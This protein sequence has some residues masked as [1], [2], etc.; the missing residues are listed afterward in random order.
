LAAPLFLALV[1]VAWVGFAPVRLGAVLQ[2]AAHVN[3][4][5]EAPERAGLHRAIIFS[6]LPFAPRCGGVPGH[7]VVFRPTNDPD[8][9]NDVLWVNHLD[10]TRDQQLLATLPGRIGYVLDWRSDCTVRVR[11]L[12]GLSSADAPPGPLKP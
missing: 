3:Q 2:V 10:V 8:L 11:P 9:R 5:L 12:A 7:F 4:A 6:P 1:L